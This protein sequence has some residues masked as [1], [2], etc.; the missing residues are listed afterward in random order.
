MNIDSFYILVNI[1]WNIILWHF[2][3]IQY[4]SNNQINLAHKK[5]SILFIKIS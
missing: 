3:K 4:N 2:D 1:L 5:N